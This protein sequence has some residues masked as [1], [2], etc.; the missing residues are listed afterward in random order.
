MSEENNDVQVKDVTYKLD[1]VLSM[2]TKALK[3]DETLVLDGESNG[4]T[5]LQKLLSSAVEDRFKTV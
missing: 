5:E 1:E 2:F 4:R 3:L